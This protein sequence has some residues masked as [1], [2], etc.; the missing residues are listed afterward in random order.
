MNDESRVGTA[1]VP[2]HGEP[3]EI[4]P[5]SPPTEQ[6]VDPNLRYDAH[7]SLSVD[8]LFESF[9][10]DPR[11]AWYPNADPPPFGSPGVHEFE[12]WPTAQRGLVVRAN[13]PAS[14]HTA[15]PYVVIEASPLQPTGTR[16]RAR[17][18]RRPPGVQLSQMVRTVLMVTCV[19]TILGTIAYAVVLPLMLFHPS[20]WM[21]A[22]SSVAGI[23]IL[24]QYSK[25]RPQPESMTAFG[26]PLWGLVGNKLVPHA[27]GGGE[28]PFRLE[29]LGTGR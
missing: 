8:E 28:D 29:A 4:N 11:V 21:M 14:I 23:G 25:N 27:L 3:E 22:I 26:G 5:Y 20:L 10:E 1:L 13:V 2:A 7:I 19:L 6:V 9:A 16:V 12:A 18:V 17:F 15:S 24:T